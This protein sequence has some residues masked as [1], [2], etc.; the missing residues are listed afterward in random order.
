MF[1]RKSDVRRR[2]EAQ[3]RPYLRNRAQRAADLSGVRAT[4]YEIAASLMVT[5]GNIAEAQR[6]FITTSGIDLGAGYFS[7]RVKQSP[8][9]LNFVKRLRLQRRALRVAN[10][11][12]CT[13]CGHL[14]NPPVKE[15]AA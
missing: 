3:L 7:R 9:L 2:L 1:A 13:E 15:S 8:D 14:M 10:H 12:V 4:T 6:L 11:F 5:G